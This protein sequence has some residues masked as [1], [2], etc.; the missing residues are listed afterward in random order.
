MYSIAAT[1]N[2]E[3]VFTGLRDGRIY[4]FDFQASLK[5][6]TVSHKSHIPESVNRNGVALGLWTFRD[7][8]ECPIFSLVV[9]SKALWAL[10]GSRNQIRLFSVRHEEGKNIAQLNHNGNISC[11][12]LTQDEEHLVS[13][14]WDFSL[15]VPSY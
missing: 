15:I 2:F 1:E 7:R 6:K 4:R 12:S 3:W 10:A 9:H 14:S 8:S 5:S 11:L 13:G